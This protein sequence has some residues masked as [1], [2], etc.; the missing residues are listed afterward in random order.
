M[1]DRKPSKLKQKLK[2]LLYRQ[3][4]TKN[5][6]EQTRK[7]EDKLAELKRQIDEQKKMRTE[8]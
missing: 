3:L 4:E 1:K 5:L 2:L 8:M 6:E 7:M